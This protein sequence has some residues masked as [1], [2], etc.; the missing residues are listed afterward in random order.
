[1]YTP[2]QN[3]I[4]VSIHAAM[5][6]T[7]YILVHVYTFYRINLTQSQCTIL[8]VFIRKLGKKYH[9]VIRQPFNICFLGS[10]F[11]LFKR[12]FAFFYKK[13]FCKIKKKENI[14]KKLKN[15]ICSITFI[16]LNTVVICLFYT[17]R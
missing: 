14:F 1:M 4:R 17:L 8:P 13:M 3:M 12:F 7:A 15:Y 6:Y 2:S 9:R 10:F 5:L 11:Q 16:T